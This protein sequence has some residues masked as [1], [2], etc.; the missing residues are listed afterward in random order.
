MP[1]GFGSPIG[2]LEEM[3]NIDGTRSVR[4]TISLPSTA[5][6]FFKRSEAL[7]AQ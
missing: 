4:A 7:T 1:R 5:I 6:G 2:G 3:W